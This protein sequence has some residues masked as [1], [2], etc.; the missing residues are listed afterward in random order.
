MASA[1]MPPPSRAGSRRPEAGDGGMM[2]DDEVHVAASLVSRLI[3]GQFP[4]WAGLPIHPIDSAGTDNAIY[5][6]GGDMAVR[7][8][9]RP[10][11]AEQVE[12]ENRWLPSL[13]PHLPLGVPVPL[14]MGMPAEGYPYRWCICRWLEGENAA[15]APIADLEQATTALAQFV[16]ALQKIGSTDGPQPGTH[17][18]FRGVPLAEMHRLELPSPACTA[19]SIPTR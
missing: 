18:F 8:P 11:A 12:K 10:A 1:M 2:R 13:A 16:S 5:R 14:A 3:A 17:N 7:L 15:V 19:C 9:L 6:L 4:D